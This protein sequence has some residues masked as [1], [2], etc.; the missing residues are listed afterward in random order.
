MQN[1]LLGFVPLK[2]ISS[3]M[4]Q[5]LNAAVAHE[6][7]KLLL[8]SGE[9]FIQPR[10][11]LEF[12]HELTERNKP[13]EDSQCFASVSVSVHSKIHEKYSLFRT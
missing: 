3:W 5:L 9:Q 2:L 4:A 11:V 8:F 7:D 6:Q 12:L 10:M 13:L 1:A